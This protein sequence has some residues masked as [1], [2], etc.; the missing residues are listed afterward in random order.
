MLCPLKS[1]INVC[2]PTVTHCYLN[3]DIFWTLV[4]EKCS[5]FVRKKEWLENAAACWCFDND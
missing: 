5:T 3:G 2:L 1:R 4:L